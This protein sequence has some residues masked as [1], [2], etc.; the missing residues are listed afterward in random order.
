MPSFFPDFVQ[1]SG[2]IWLFHL[3]RP[4]TLIFF[5]PYTFI[6]HM[7]LSDGAD[8]LAFFPPLRPLLLDSAFHLSLVP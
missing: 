4:L 7:D 8:A 2:R 6:S 5:S 3:L 1:L